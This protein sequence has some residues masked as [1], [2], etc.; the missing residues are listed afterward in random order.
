LFS[1]VVPFK[2]DE[3]RKAFAKG[4]ISSTNIFQLYEF[5]FLKKS[6]TRFPSLIGFVESLCA[7]VFC[8]LNFDG[9]LHAA[10]I[11]FV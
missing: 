5:L 4:G 1:V 3:N 9:K 11:R 6:G 10:G 2:I 8:A 7:F